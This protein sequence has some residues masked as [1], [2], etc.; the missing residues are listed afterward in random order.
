MSN[1]ETDLLCNQIEP[2]KLLHPFDNLK[3]TYCDKDNVICTRY[4]NKIKCFNKFIPYQST[5]IP[6]RLCKRCYIPRLIGFTI[7]FE[8]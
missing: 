2:Q 6:S 1:I 3:Q 8:N 7:K 5:S 4:V